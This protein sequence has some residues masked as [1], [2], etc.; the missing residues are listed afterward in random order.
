MTDY[1][2]GGEENV[3]LIAVERRQHTARYYEWNGTLIN[4][5]TPLRYNPVQKHFYRD[6]VQSCGLPL[7]YKRSTLL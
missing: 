2:T 1:V 3:I 6:Q 4:V 5:R 7:D